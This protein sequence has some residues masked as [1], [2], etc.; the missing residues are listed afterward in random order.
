MSEHFLP[1]T[2]GPTAPL[3]D[4]AAQAL[5]IDPEKLRRD[6]RLV[7]ARFW[8]KLRDALGK[9]PFVEDALAAYFA[10][11]DPATPFKAKAVLMGAL[12]YFIL[13]VDAL[14]DVVALL[15]YTDDTAVLLLALRT[16]SGA[17]TPA[18]YDRA[19]GWLDAH[20]GEGGR[21]A[22][23]AGSEKEPGATG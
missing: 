6:S 4:T 20:R 18:H 2:I 14:P 17:L 21:S 7:L 3:D 13:P 10:A 8:T 16:V 22:T 15:G 11:T 23:P 9:V 19:R 12:A 1:V 5:R